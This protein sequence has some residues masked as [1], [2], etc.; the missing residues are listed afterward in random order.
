MNAQEVLDAVIAAIMTM[1]A[2][3]RI[4]AETIPQ[5]F[6]RPCFFVSANQREIPL[7]GQRYLRSF[8]VRVLWFPPDKES[9]SQDSRLVGDALTMALEWI[10]VNGLPRRA[11][12]ISIQT[13]ERDGGLEFS[14]EYAAH[15]FKR[16]DT[17]KMAVLEHH[18]E[19]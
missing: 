6:S 1:D 8:D 16:M 3:A 5:G 10:E 9:A 12:K 14:A 18:I 2:Q 15:I 11:A 4:Y 17:E 19:L 7:M 13:H